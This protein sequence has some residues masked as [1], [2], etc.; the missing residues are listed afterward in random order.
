M[1][2]RGRPSQPLLPR[3]VGDAE[4]CAAAGRYREALLLLRWASRICA[5]DDLPVVLLAYHRVR[6][7]RPRPLD[8]G[9]SRVPA[10]TEPAR[11]QVAGGGPVPADHLGFPVPRFPTGPLSIDTGGFVP[12]PR[13]HARVPAR[14][15]SAPPPGPARRRSRAFPLGLAAAGILA[16]WVVRGGLPDGWG[17]LVETAPPSAHG[18]APA[19]ADDAAPA[20]LLARGGALLAAGDTGAAIA[21]LD[22]ASAHPLAGHRE[23][24][25]AAEQL[26]RLPGGAERAANAYLRAFEAGLPRE[27][28]P[29]AA[30]ALERAGRP[31]QAE[32]LRSLIQGPP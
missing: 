4:S 6:A 18:S 22:S 20:V 23:A 3:L 31:Q 32:R 8:P 25:E 7:A 19:P 30:A 10:G 16:L 5:D 11:L 17:I 2:T 1:S 21:A 26:T 29:V 28:W 12:A 15:S 24:R 27:E 13:V 9:P 14:G